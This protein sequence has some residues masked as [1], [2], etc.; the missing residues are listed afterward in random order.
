MKKCFIIAAVAAIAFAITAD[1]AFAVDP[2][3]KGGTI[4]LAAG[5]TNV[6]TYVSLLTDVEA[7]GAFDVF[8]EIESIT[9]IN[10]SGTATGTI[11]VASV[12][13]GVDTTILEA[14]AHAPAVSTVNYPTR[15]Q[16]ETL[17][18]SYITTN[19]PLTYVANDTTNYLMRDILVTVA[20]T[21]TRYV[22]Y[23][24]RMLKI[25]VVQDASTTDTV[26]KYAIFAK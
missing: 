1:V 21:T 16:L 23:G 17:G 20:P 19:A 8:R 4:T 3:Y 7:R 14:G 10:N 2:L 5:E 26:Y 6:N 13:V 18:S 25:N 22:K 24:C 15:A 9:F 11:T 12:N